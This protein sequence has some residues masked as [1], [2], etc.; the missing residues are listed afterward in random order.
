MMR[1]PLFSLLLALLAAAP[2]ARGQFITATEVERWLSSD[3]P[4]SDFN[5]NS[6]YVYLLNANKLKDVFAGEGLSRSARK[7]LSIKKG[8]FPQ[9][10]YLAVT[11]PDPNKEQGSFTVPLMI[12]DVQ[13]PNDIARINGYGGRLLENIPD[14]VL[15]KGDILGTVK[16]EAFK[17]NASEEFWKKTAQ[18][19]IDLG[20]TA[21][22]LLAAPLTGNFLA[23]ANQIV[24]QVS[25]GINSLEHVDDPRKISSEFYIRLL[26]KELSGLYEERVVSSTLYRIHWDVE[27]RPAKTVFFRNANPARVDDL[28]RMV[29]QNSP[30]FI[31]VAHTKSE[32]N[33]DHSE[34]VYNQSYIEKKTRD[35]RKIQNAAK[36]E[37]EKE[38]LE[39][40]KSALELKNQ[41]DIFQNSLNTKY[42]DW[43]A[44]SRVIDLYHDIRQAKNQQLAKIAGAERATVDKYTNL[45]NNVS[46]DVSL[47]FNTELL[48]RA[49]NI[50]EYL[51]GASPDYDYTYTPSRVIY[52]DIETLDFYRDR[53][54][55]TEIQGKLPKEIETL[56]SYLLT[57]RILRN[58]ETHLFNKEFRAPAQLPIAEQRRWLLDK[59]TNQYPLCQ[60][61]GER[62]GD[63]IVEIENRSHEENIAKYRQISAEYY[64]KLGCYEQFFS[65]LNGIIRANSDSLTL[66]PMVFEALKKDKAE[67]DRLTDTYSKIIGRDYTAM[68]P[69]ELS[70]VLSSYYLNREKLSGVMERLRPIVQ[71]ES[72]AAC[73]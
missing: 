43:L 6:A 73:L 5:L 13:N 41:I 33:T 12:H 47:W 68:K 34:L 48:T 22:S 36:K 39:T 7:E 28:R 46:N 71:L 3:M 63:R 57:N 58:L 50:A 14:E 51:V 38:F 29:N 49:R 26:D 20:K 27:G 18:I 67:L 65:K 24:P 44:Y 23:L 35:Y 25:K 60:V 21:T 70:E 32:Y 10:M 40:F 69:Q 66:S 8:D 15:K 61:C 56:R 19:S 11:I 37:I 64:E 54:K 17:G 2:L 31:L 30:V 1:V 16:F 52:Q 59:A 42:P 53:V 9:Y 55:Q 45:Y 4:P 72:S 62:V